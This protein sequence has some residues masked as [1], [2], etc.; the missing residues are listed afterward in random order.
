MSA[1]IPSY[2][3]VIDHRIRTMT[4]SSLD[5]QLPR[6]RA[7][8]TPHR[9]LSSILM[10]SCREF[11]LHGHFEM[12]QRLHILFTSAARMRWT[13]LGYRRIHMATSCDF[14]TRG[15]LSALTSA[16]DLTRTMIFCLNRY[17]QTFTLAG[18]HHPQKSITQIYYLTLLADYWDPQ[19]RATTLI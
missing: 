6:R 1:F 4:P 8:P 9:R 13:C 2:A 7:A 12:R 18:R 14:L 3:Q 15:I 17:T 16:S 11:R 19:K 5:I 10:S